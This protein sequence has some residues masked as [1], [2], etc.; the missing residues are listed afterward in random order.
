MFRYFSTLIIILLLFGGCA[1]PSKTQPATASLHGNS[2]GADNGFIPQYRLG[3]GDVIDVKFFR[4]TEFNET[5]KV[6][7]DG[8]ISLP[9]VGEIQV[10][11]MTPLQLDSV[12]TRSYDEFV[13]N[14]EITVIVREFSGNQ[15]YILG[16]VHKAGGYELSKD[17]S[18]LQA[19]AVAGGAMNSAKL[20]S[21]MILRK[22][23]HAELTATKISISDYLQ[24]NGEIE[25][26]QEY[27]L[28]KPQDI[29]FVPKTAISS[30]ADF[31]KMIYTGMLPP[32]DLYLR[33]TLYYDRR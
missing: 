20:N 11:G 27:L 25:Y 2:E 23:R 32:L 14:P 24:G 15:F 22:N 33:A 19:L 8:R 30:A 31:M 3:F 9:R 1:G 16:E 7:P 6:R 4:N 26:S 18:I 17:L 21:V 28:V 10:T 29:I 12:I 5:V 13:V